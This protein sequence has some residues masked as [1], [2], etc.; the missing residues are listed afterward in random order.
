MGWGVDMMASKSP[1]FER[2]VTL[3]N[4]RQVSYLMMAS[5]VFIFSVVTYL[6]VFTYNDPSKYN[7]NIENNHRILLKSKIVYVGDYLY[8]AYSIHS[9]LIY[10]FVV[11]M[12]L[13]V[14]FKRNTA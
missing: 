8:Y 10:F 5:A 12:F 4:S 3:L 2:L 7:P 14:I 11:V 13:R 9:Y 1:L 6:Y